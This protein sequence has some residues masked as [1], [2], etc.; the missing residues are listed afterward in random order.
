MLN[1]FEVNSSVRFLQFKKITLEGRRQ[2]SSKRL[3]CAGRKGQ[4]DP[5]SPKALC[6]RG[7]A[8]WPL[9]CHKLLLSPPASPTPALSAP[10]WCLNCAEWALAS[11]GPAQPHAATLP[12]LSSAGPRIRSR[13]VWGAGG[14]RAPRVPLVP[15]AREEHRVCLPCKV[16]GHS[17]ATMGPRR[18]SGTDCSATRIREHSAGFALGEERKSPRICIRPWGCL[19][20]GVTARLGG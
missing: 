11:P 5:M 13:G 18:L 17:R 16:P 6:L 7:T 4:E 14:E 19:P 12:H 1:S 15:R 8:R 20:F 2:G 3:L 10:G 9:S